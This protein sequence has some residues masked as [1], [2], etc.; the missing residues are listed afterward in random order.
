MPG[1]LQHLDDTKQCEDTLD[2]NPE[3]AKLWLPSEL[4]SDLIDRLCM[5]DVRQVEAK[6]QL[7]RCFDSLH[8]VRHTLRVKTRMM[9]FKNTNIRGQRDSGKS[10]EVINR[11]VRRARW[12]AA[13]YRVAREAYLKLAGPGSWEAVLKPLRNEDVRSYRD[14]ALMK[15]RKGRK[16][17]EE[18][19]EKEEERLQRYDDYV[20][21]EEE[22]DEMERDEIT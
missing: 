4:P 1:L 6:L 2:A 17:T 21:R 11:V 3:N 18:E 16:G 22:N 9:L 14:P 10:R 12:Y 15:T 5:K 8:G 19:D 13:R 20:S 7:A